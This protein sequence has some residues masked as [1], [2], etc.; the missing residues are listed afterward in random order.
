[1]SPEAVVVSGRKWGFPLFNLVKCS[2]A[3]ATVCAANPDL[4]ENKGPHKKKR[5]A[6]HCGGALLSA[7][8]PLREKVLLN[9]IERDCSAG[10]H[11]NSAFISITP[12]LH[13]CLG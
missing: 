1:L 6:S 9:I 7:S 10:I 8:E 4:G 12:L 5:T 13:T 3:P 2:L 11:Q